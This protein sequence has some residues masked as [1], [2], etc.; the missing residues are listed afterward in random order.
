MELPADVPILLRVTSSKRPA[1]ANIDTM[2]IA[3]IHLPPEA[4]KKAL[5][6]RWEREA[7]AGLP[8]RPHPKLEAL[9][10]KAPAADASEQE[11]IDYKNLIIEADKVQG[12]MDA[13]TTLVLHH[14]ELM[15]LDADILGKANA[16]VEYAP[17]ISDLAYSIYQQAI[18]YANDPT[19]DNWVNPAPATG[20]DLHTP[21]P[22]KTQVY[23]WSDATRQAVA[24]PGVPGPLAATLQSTKNDPEL[25][26]WSYVVQSGTTTIGG[27]NQPAPRMFSKFKRPAPSQAAA[28]GG[29]GAR[30]VTRD[31]TPH[32]GV[33]YSEVTFED[34][35]FSMKLTNDWIRWLSVYVEFLGPDG[36]TLIAPQGWKSFLPAT[37]SDFESDTQKYLLWCSAR[38]TILGIPLE[39]SPAE[40]SF[41]WPTNNPS[42][43]RI[44]CGG[45]GILNANVD[46]RSVGGW[47]TRVCLGGAILTGIL[48]FAL[49]TI[50]LVAGAAF[51]FGE[52]MD[53]DVKEGIEGFLTVSRLIIEGPIAAELAGGE[54]KILFVAFANTAIDL[55]L[56]AVPK[57]AAKLAAEITVEEIADAVP[58]AGWIAEVISLAADAALLIETTV[59]VLSSYATIELD[60]N[61]VMDVTVIVYPDPS[62]AGG[63]QWPSQSDHW[64]A[65]L[66]YRDGT[67]YQKTGTLDPA[68]TAG[69]IAVKFASVPAGGSLKAIFAV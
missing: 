14:P 38:D 15:S 12:A 37:F 1:A 52:D 29:N 61:K 8:M 21:D 68:T 45:L 40:I 67:T 32:S 28:G 25:Q 26:N 24:T 58:V 49:P 9:G 11:K 57:V 53:E 48:N 4:R 2:A 7:A 64:Q 20:P 13:A 54:I 41:P 16:Y 33:E 22:R 43:V 69:P 36:V 10:V 60:V 19:Q 63:K 23:R 50:F 56:K 27:A 65:T 30:L 6:A 42:A 59:E 55:L 34:G 44:L 18:K 31:V 35:K 51:T 17:G 3:A 5:L 66:Q 39:A 46:G 62:S 47:D